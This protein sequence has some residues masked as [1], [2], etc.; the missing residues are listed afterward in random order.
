MNF[1]WQPSRK[2]EDSIDDLDGGAGVI[3]G[4]LEVQ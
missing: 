4:E 3:D 2:E 1:A